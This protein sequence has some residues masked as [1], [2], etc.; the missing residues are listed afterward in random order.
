MTRLMVNISLSAKETSYLFGVVVLLGCM[1][2]C[3]HFCLALTLN[4]A[5][6]LV[7]F[8]I[9]EFL[10]PLDKV[11]LVFLLNVQR[12]TCDRQLYSTISGY[13]IDKILVRTVIR[14]H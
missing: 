5:I 4:K 7:L 12:Q 1:V 2:R 3:D 6:T 9:M 8:I 13:F 14:Y 11:V 10:T